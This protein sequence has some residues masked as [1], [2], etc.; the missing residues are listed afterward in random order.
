MICGFIRCLSLQKRFF[1]FKMVYLIV[2][3]CVIRM[4]RQDMFWVN[5]F[6]RLFIKLFCHNRHLNARPLLFRHSFS[7]FSISPWNVRFC[8]L[9][10]M[11]IVL[12][13]HQTVKSNRLTRDLRLW[14]LQQFFFCHFSKRFKTC[15]AQTQTEKSHNPKH[16]Q[17]KQRFPPGERKIAIFR[18]GHIKRTFESST[19]YFDTPWLLYSNQFSIVQWC[20]MNNSL[21]MGSK[22]KWNIHSIDNNFSSSRNGCKKIEST[23]RYGIVIMTRQEFTV[24]KCRPIQVGTCDIALDRSISVYILHTT[25]IKWSLNAKIWWAMKKYG[26]KEKEP[27]KSSRRIAT[28]CAHIGD[29]IIKSYYIHLFHLFSSSLSSSLSMVRLFIAIILFLFFL[30]IYFF[31]HSKLSN[32]FHMMNGIRFMAHFTAEIIVK[33]I[34]FSLRFVKLAFARR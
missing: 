28:L 31:F 19:A 1:F 34:K 2:I 10:V 18:F 11:P 17:S 27:P 13:I 15:N 24:L 12:F 32:T 26:V 8:V 3:C 4:N 30:Y 6:F 21:S 33:I 7:L 5:S 25:T 16:S 20:W 22:P 29:W 14:F 23:Q 9:F